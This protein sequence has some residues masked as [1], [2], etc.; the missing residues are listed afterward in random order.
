MLACMLQKLEAIGCL[1]T[2]SRALTTPLSATQ[3]GDRSYVLTGSTSLCSIKLLYKLSSSVKHSVSACRIPI[4]LRNQIGVA[5]TDSA[6]LLDIAVGLGIEFIVLQSPGRPEILRAANR[7]CEL[8]DL[9]N[10]VGKAVPTNTSQKVEMEKLFVNHGPVFR[11]R[12]L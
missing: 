5:F 12:L 4:C 7:Y 11:H 2:E 9:F 8:S 3:Q 10:D 1:G 6:L